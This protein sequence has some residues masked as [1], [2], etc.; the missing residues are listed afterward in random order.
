LLLSL[1]ARIKTDFMVG[2]VDVSSP[3]LLAMAYVKAW[4]DGNGPLLELPC[5]PPTTVEEIYETHDAMVDL[6]PMGA[7]GDLGGYKMGAVG[8]VPG[9]P[10]FY[11][12]LFRNFFSHHPQEPRM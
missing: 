2:V 10:C 7:F 8:L 4:T 9:V 6:A 11:G 3:A 12:P 5:A 1:K